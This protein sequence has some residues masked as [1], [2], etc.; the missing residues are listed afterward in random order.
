MVACKLLIVSVCRPRVHLTGSPHS[1][2]W[3]GSV[4][5]WRQ[6]NIKLCQDASV[7]PR[8]PPEWLGSYFR[9]YDSKSV[10]FVPNTKWD[11][12]DASGTS[13]TAHELPIR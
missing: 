2:L 6:D 3:D 9:R 10:S 8:V 11:R 1:S 5:R 4:A 7:M 12:K 13:R